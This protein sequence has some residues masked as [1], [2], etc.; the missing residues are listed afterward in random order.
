MAFCESKN[1]DCFKSVVPSGGCAEGP[2]ME[3]K[4]LTLAELQGELLKL[5]LRFDA[6]CKERGA[7]LLARFR[8][9]AR[10]GSAQGVHPW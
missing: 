4:Y 2:D 7:S 9:A 5:L 10:G 6:F 3:L 8:H 1:E